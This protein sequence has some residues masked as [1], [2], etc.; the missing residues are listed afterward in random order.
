MSITRRAGVTS[1]RRLHLT[2]AAPVAVGDK[3]PSIALYEN[4]PGNKVDAAELCAGR[5]VVVFGVPGAFTPGCS[6]THLPGYVASAASMR[7]KGVEEIV[8]ISVNDP[9]VMEAW[10][11]EQGVAGK[12]RMLADPQGSLTSAL[13]LGLDM[14]AI[15]GNVRC[16]RFAMVVE[17]GVVTR[18]NVE[19]DGVGLSCSLAGMII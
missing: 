1:V 10:G 19:P 8:C 6:N 9:F 2:P 5:K 18:L 4:S 12:V 13:G 3:L 14:A 7:E 17:D 15:L 11:R 16:K